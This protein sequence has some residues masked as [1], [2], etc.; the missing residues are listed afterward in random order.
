MLGLSGAAAGCLFAYAGLDALVSLLPQNPLPGE[1]EIRLDGAALVVSLGTAVAS[2]LLFGIA[3]ALY[4]ARRDLV[5]GLKSGGKTMAGS[6]GTLRNALVAA[7]I[8]LSLVLLL[9]AGLL[10]RTFTSLMRIDSGFNPDKLLVVPLAFAPSAYSVAA[11]KYRFY[12]TALQRIAALPGVEAVAASSYLPPVRWPLQ[13]GFR[14]LWHRPAR[15]LQRQ[16]V[17]FLEPRTTFEHWAS[18]S[19][20]GTG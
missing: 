7:E 16:L 19:C 20:E 3:P 9:S 1:V 6:R 10:M 8:A 17:Q 14:H 15:V 18:A 5:E 4:S 11:D 12:D 13:D 2:A